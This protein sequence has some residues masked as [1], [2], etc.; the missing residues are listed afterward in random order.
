MDSSNN[1]E[2][3]VTSQTCS[4]CGINHRPEPHVVRVTSIELDKSGWIAKGEGRVPSF[5]PYCGSSCYAIVER[6]IPIHC[7]T[8]KCPK[9]KGKED[10]SYDVTGVWVDE[11]DFEFKASISCKKCGKLS[12]L[13]EIMSKLLNVLQLEISLTGISVRKKDSP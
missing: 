11:D 3:L 6:S 13:T 4:A 5:C 7:A 10:L 8:L 1:L 2:L 9:C 12:S